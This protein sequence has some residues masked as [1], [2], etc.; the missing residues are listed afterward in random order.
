MNS[1]IIAVG[2]DKKSNR[3]ISQIS[4]NSDDNPSDKTD[5]WERERQK[6]L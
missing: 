1:S 5:L 2:L 6:R 3:K 4:G